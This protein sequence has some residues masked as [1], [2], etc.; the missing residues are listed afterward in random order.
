MPEELQEML[1]IGAQRW[2]SDWASPHM[3]LAWSC[4]GCGCASSGGP[5]QA[6]HESNA[7]SR[8]RPAARVL[9]PLAAHLPGREP[10]RLLPVGW[11]R[12]AGC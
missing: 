8:K 10:C 3:D 5:A 6:A 9:M 4:C 2:P 11:V 1:T 12:I 7:R